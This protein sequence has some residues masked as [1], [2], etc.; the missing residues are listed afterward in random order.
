M[1]AP[2]GDPF[3]RGTGFQNQAGHLG[4]QT[5]AQDPLQP[6][7]PGPSQGKPTQSPLA[8]DDDHGLV[9]H[10]ISELN[11]TISAAHTKAGLLLS[12]VGLSWPAWQLASGLP[13]PWLAPDL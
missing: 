5:E 12:G 13:R 1:K 7:H 11:R 6:L 2:L 9:L 8:P 10:M 3:K 4:G